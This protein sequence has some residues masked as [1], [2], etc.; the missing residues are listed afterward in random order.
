MSLKLDLADPD[1][2]VHDPIAH[3][4]VKRSFETGGFVF[5]KPKVS[6]PS[7]TVTAQQAV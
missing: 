4:A 7:E 6:N 5:L 1:V 2:L 3:E